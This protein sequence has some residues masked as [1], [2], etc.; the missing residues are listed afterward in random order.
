MLPRPKFIFF[1]VDK[2]IQKSVVLW[3]LD[4]MSFCHTLYG[5]QQAVVCNFSCYQLFFLKR[6]PVQRN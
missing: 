2:Y 4:D 1:Y 3:H 6:I 5:S